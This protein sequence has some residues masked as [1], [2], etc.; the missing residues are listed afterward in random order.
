MSEKIPAHARPLAFASGALMLDLMYTLR[1]YY[2]VDLESI[3]I[4]LCVNDAN[5]QFLMA[6]ED[7]PLELLQAPDLPHEAVQGISRLMV[8]DKTGLPRESVRR[9]CR[10]LISAGHLVA[11]ESDRL[12][13][14][15]D[16]VDPAARQTV[17]NSHA[18]V[19][20]YVATA[21][22]FGIAV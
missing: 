7:V 5:M 22:R 8:A 12:R 18:A 9:K 1:A 20:R 6:K 4:L 2:A 21:R 14:R 10:E 13:L 3:Q 15:L 16:L 19:Q 17:D 11:D